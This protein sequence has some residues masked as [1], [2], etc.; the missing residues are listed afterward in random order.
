MPGY[1]L[2]CWFLL[3]FKEINQYLQALS[4]LWNKKK[5][6]GNEAEEIPLKNETRLCGHAVHGG[7]VQPFWLE[8]TRSW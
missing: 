7:W 4:A 8:Q 3:S 2:K 6:P 1:E 5:N